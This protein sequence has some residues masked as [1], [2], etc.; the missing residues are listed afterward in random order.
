MLSR[1]QSLS[2]LFKVGRQFTA[3]LQLF[4]GNRVFESEFGGV[5]RLPR[6]ARSHD[7]RILSKRG[8]PRLET[9]AICRVSQNRMADM[10]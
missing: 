3:K 9:S 4:A 2:K 10:R 7:L 6:Q 8:E 1:L 5:E